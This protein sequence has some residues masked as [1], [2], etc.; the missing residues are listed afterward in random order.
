MVPQ[1]CIVE[2]VA[3]VAERQFWCGGSEGKSTEIARELWNTYGR[4][5]LRNR[6]KEELDKLVGQSGVN[7][8]VCDQFRNCNRRADRWVILLS[9]LLRTCHVAAVLQVFRR[10]LDSVPGVPPQKPF[11]TA[12]RI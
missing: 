11:Q 5:G 6:A 12:T 1:E 4:Q 9:R 3:K 8:C 2:T 10:D 7:S